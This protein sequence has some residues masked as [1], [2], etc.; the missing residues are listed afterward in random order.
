M[1]LFQQQRVNNHTVFIVFTSFVL[2]LITRFARS[3]ELQFYVNKSEA[4]WTN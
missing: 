3:W 2:K 1:A 4:K